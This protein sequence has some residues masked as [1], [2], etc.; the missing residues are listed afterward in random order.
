MFCTTRQITNRQVEYH[1]QTFSMQ[2]QQKSGKFAFV[3]IDIEY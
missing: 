1:G 2:V 3:I